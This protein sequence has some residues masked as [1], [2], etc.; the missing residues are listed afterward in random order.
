[1]TAFYGI[2]V[3]E[4]QRLLR[5]RVRLFAAFLRPMI[6]LFV[7]GSGVGAIVASSDP[8]AYRRFMLPGVLGMVLLFGAILAAMSTATDRE[9]GAIRLLLIAP[10]S[11]TLLVLAKIAGTTMVALAQGCVLLL[12]LPLLAPQTEAVEVVLL[13]LAMT[14]T[15]ATLAAVGMALASSVQSVESFG[16]AANFVA[17]P[18]L[19]LSGALYP[20]RVLPAV[21]QPLTIVNPLTYGI[22]LMKHALLARGAGRFGPELPVVVDV[23]ALLLVF[24]LCATLAV[25]LFDGEARFTGRLR[26]RGQG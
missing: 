2:V 4:L 25:F 5:R 26:L 19:F 7:V 10:V 13:V 24:A 21:L 16:G 9:L 17:F 18:M 22:D 15:A 6:W 20:S 12:L 14:V 8:D 11:R 1:M 3:R 23:G